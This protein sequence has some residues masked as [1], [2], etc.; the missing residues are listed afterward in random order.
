MPA[1]PAPTDAAAHELTGPWRAT[2]ADEDLR[3]A[4]PDL[5]YDDDAWT[6]VALPHHWRHEPAFTATDG[7]LLYR[8]RFDT[9][10]TFGA[11][12]DRADDADEPRRTWLTLDGVFYTSDVWFDG[13]YLGDTEGYFFPH[14]FEVSD[15]LRAQSEHVL[16]L[17][18][19]CRPEADRTAKR[20]LTGAFQHADERDRDANPGGIWRPVRLEQTGPVRITHLRVLCR[21]ANAEAATVSVRAVL[22]TVEARTVTIDTHVTPVHPDAPLEIDASHDPATITLRTTHP[23]ATG[24]NRLEW[25]IEVPQP[26]LWWPHALGGQPRYDVRIDV[27]TG[28]ADEQD[29]PLL[30]SDRC[31]RRIGLR[32]VTMRD[33]VFSV[34]GE[35]LFLK[36]ANQG[37]AMVDLAAATDDDFVRDVELAKAANLDFLRV[38]AH[39]S[40]PAL[41]DAADAAGLLLWQDMPL[42]WGYHRSIRKQARRQARELVDLVGHHPS[43]FVW[44]GHN[45]PLAIDIGPDPTPPA[46]APARIGARGFVGQLLPA[47]NKSVLDTSIKRVIEKHDSSR[48]V[49][50]HSGVLPHLPQLDGTDSHLWFGWHYSDVATFPTA[51]RLWPRLAR[52]VSELGAQALPAHADFAEPDRWPDLDWERLRTHHGM[53]VAAFTAHVD[54]ADFA[55]FDAWREASQAYQARLLR[56]HV[57]ALRLLKYAPTGGFA[58]SSFADGFPA[59]TTAVLDVDRTPKAGYE[60]LAAACAPVIVVAD[61]L[62]ERVRP[63]DALALDVHVVSDARISLS[64]M[65]VTAHLCWGETATRSLDPDRSAPEPHIGAPTGSRS[66]AHANSHEWRWQGDVPADSCS[67]IGT[68][69]VV[70]PDCPGPLALELSLDRGPGADP[71]ARVVGLPAAPGLPVRRHDRAVIER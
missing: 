35:R 32:S 31:R 12:A 61:P 36:G 59:I 14:S 4:Y 26:L 60:A 54:P 64:D 23:I 57:E 46:Q 52:F 67:R 30:L 5:E 45:E 62:P 21:D 47:W 70:V 15:A 24:E 18:V 11:G 68:I 53:H 69:Q 34:N 51:L 40:K 1:R 22:D 39:V 13:S 16:A 63:G 43:V 3:R 65:I 55:S 17:E 33:W 27:H 28:D 58:V 8:T 41:Y 48:P 56:A 38:Q 37:P 42:Q 7:P 66:G 20:N 50:P 2:V 49:I 29:A 9:P 10:E 25:T 6:A 44:C 71:T 19:S